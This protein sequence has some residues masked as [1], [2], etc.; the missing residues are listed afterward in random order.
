MRIISVVLNRRQKSKL[1]CHQNSLPRSYQ[2]KIM[3][4]LI[5][6]TSESNFGARLGRRSNLIVI[7]PWSSVTSTELQT[8][9]LVCTANVV[10]CR[11]LWGA[12]A[13]V[14]ARRIKPKFL[15]QGSTPIFGS[16]PWNVGWIRTS[17]ESLV[18]PAEPLDGSSSSWCGFCQKCLKNICSCHVRHKNV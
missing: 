15:V 6:A 9:K 7:P 12:Q 16:G 18:A 3:S 5:D 17:G 10:G 1:D 14:I 8:F 2:F 4:C 13:R 11:S